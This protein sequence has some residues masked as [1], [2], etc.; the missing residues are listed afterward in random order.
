MQRIALFLLLLPLVSLC[1]HVSAAFAQEE[2]PIRFST[3][4]ADV[5]AI[6]K[7]HLD[8]K[9][10][11]DGKDFDGMMATFADDMIL[12]PPCSGDVVGKA[13]IDARGR[14]WFE[15]QWQSD[16]WNPQEVL[17]DVEAVVAGDLGFL[18]GYGTYPMEVD[19]DTIQMRDKYIWILKRQPDGSWKNWRMISNT[20]KCKCMW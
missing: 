10:A 7:V 14:W 8:Y 9:A 16:D 19:G 20:D 11:M 17:N 1:L 5:E 18:R 12:I 6:K 15:S 2:A 3:D 13:R 4:G